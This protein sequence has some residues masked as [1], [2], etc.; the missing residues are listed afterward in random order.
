VFDCLH[1]ALVFVR[2]RRTTGIIVSISEN[3]S[4]K[5][6]APPAE[7]D[8]ASGIVKV[9][10]TNTKIDLM[11]GVPLGFTGHSWAAEAVRWVAVELANRFDHSLV[12]GEVQG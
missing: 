7:G 9:K 2:D 6:Q 5:L 1:A 10:V 8:Q 4:E 11:T 3:K 12:A